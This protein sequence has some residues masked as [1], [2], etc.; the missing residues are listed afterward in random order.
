M[1]PRQKK[2]TGGVLWK[3]ARRPAR[4]TQPKICARFINRARRSTAIH[5]KPSKRSPHSFSLSLSLPHCALRVRR[6]V[7]AARV[8]RAAPNNHPPETVHSSQEIADDPRRSLTTQP[9]RVSVS[10]LTDPRTRS[11]HQG[12][13]LASRDIAARSIEQHFGPQPPRTRPSLLSA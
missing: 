13:E 6:R 4:R 3:R 2:T 11:T 7:S 5:H 8:S 1:S 10:P 12:R 9:H